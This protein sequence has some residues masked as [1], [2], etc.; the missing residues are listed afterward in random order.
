M[1]A[2]F[3][4][5]KRS[6]VNQIKKALKKPVTYLILCVVMVYIFAFGSLFISWKEAGIFTSPRSLV[7]ILTVGAVFTFF[8]E[9]CDL[10]KK[11]RN[12]IQTESLSLYFYGSNRS[13]G[14]SFDGSH[15]KLFD[16]CRNRASRVICRAVYIPDRIFQSVFSFYRMFPFGND[17][18]RFFDFIFICQ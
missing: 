14:H 6:M 17:F 16:E 13:E 10:C 3:Y 8:I 1:K 4:M 18:G 7:T 11:E 5:T 15:E 12:Y 9:F 2:L